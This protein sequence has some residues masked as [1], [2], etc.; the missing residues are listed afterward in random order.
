MQLKAVTAELKA[1]TAELKAVTAQ[2]RAATAHKKTAAVPFGGGLQGQ[3]IPLRAGMKLC[4]A[5]CVPPKARCSRAEPLADEDTV[6]VGARYNGGMDDSGY[7]PLEKLKAK[8]KSMAYGKFV[9][10]RMRGEG[11]FAN[12]RSLL[13]K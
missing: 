6:I 5:G 11:R 12:F 8:P 2:L 7:I 13:F 9:L 10:R 3:K 4:C 1:V